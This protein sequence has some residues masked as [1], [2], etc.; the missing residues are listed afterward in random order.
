ML[1]SF[2]FSTASDELHMSTKD[3]TEI[4]LPKKAGICRGLHFSYVCSGLSYGLFVGRAPM[5]KGVSAN[6]VPPQST[7]PGKGHKGIGGS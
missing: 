3:S 2:P 5:G 1:E 6:Q 7:I 4:W